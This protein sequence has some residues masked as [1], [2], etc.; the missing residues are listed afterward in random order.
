MDSNFT[1]SVDIIKYKKMAFIYNALEKGWSVR[2]KKD[3]YVFR[4]DHGDK[5]E[6]YLDSFLRRFMVSNLDIDQLMK[7]I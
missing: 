2:K 6:V 5:K 1:R 4:K 3:N 7:K